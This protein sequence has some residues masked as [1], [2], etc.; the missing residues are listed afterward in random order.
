MQIK[1]PQATKPHLTFKQLRATPRASLASQQ[2]PH[3]FANA[4]VQNSNASSEEE[5]S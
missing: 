2:N 5:T 4:Q 3:Q 1:M